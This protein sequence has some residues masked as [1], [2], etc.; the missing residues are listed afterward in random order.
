[1]QIVDPISFALRDEPPALPS[2]NLDAEPVP[3]AIKPQPISL[4]RILMPLIMEVVMLAMVAMMILTSNGAPNPMM[5]MFPMMMIA[6]MAMM[7]NPQSGQDPDESRRTYLRHLGSLRE[8]A[9]KNGQAQRKN[10]L[11]HHPAPRD[12]VQLAGTTRMWERQGSDDDAYEVRVG[13]GSATLSTPIN[14]S[15]SGATEDLDP[16]CAVSLRHTLAAVSTVTDMPI[17]LQLQAFRFLGITGANARELAR[18]M[19]LQL[20]TFHGPEAIGFRSIGQGWEWLKWLPHTRAPQQAHFVCLLVDDT[21]TTGLEPFM[22][23]PDVDCIIDI[24]SRRTTALGVRAEQEGL[25]LLADASLTVLTSD[26][27]EEL[28]RADGVSEAEAIVGARALARFS[29]PEVTSAHT[30]DDL[31]GLLGFGDVAEMTGP[32]L[33]PGRRGAARL[34]VPIGLSPSKLPVMLD[35]KESAQGGMGPHGL[36][37]GA[38]GSGKS[39]ALRTIVVSLAATH[40]PDELNFVLVDFKGGATFL[41]CD[42]LPHTAAVITNLEDESALVE[43]MYDAISGEMNRRQEI[44]RD[45]GNFAN[46][47]DYT[48]ARLSGRDDLPAL[49]ALVIVVDEFSELLMQHPDFA[50]LF[51]AVGRLGR[52][53]HVHLLLASQRLEE[54]R[55]RGL[56]SHLSYRIGLKTFSAAESRQ[57][58]GV[59]D[60]YHLPAEPGAGYLKTDADAL[61]RFQAFYVSGG[62]PREAAVHDAPGAERL[63]ISE[64]TGWDEETAEPIKVET[65]IDDSTTLL[66]EVVDATREEAAR[67]GLKAH[68]VWLAPLPPAIEL[69]AVAVDFSPPGDGQI[70]APVGIIDRPFY[71]RQDQLLVNL[72]SGHMAICGGPQSGKSMALLTIVASLAA[73]YSPDFLRFYVIDLGGGQ[74]S[75]LNRLPHVAAV[76]GRH[77][78]EKVRR[79]IDE[80]MGLVEHPESRHTYLV[81]DGWHHMGVAGADFEDLSEPI[82]RLAVDGPSARVHVIISTPRWTTMR[83]A[84]RD[85]ITERLE[86]K[87]G[88]PM[89]SLFDRKKQQKLPNLPGRGITPEGESMLMAATSRQDLAH[90]ESLWT[91]VAP[92]PELKM[93]P[94]TLSVADLVT[95]DASSELERNPDVDIR[96]PWARGGRDLETQTWDTR[97]NFFIVGTSGVGKS[98]VVATLLQGIGK[99]DRAD[100][101]IVLIDQRRAHLGTVDESMLAAYSA[102]SAATEKVLRDTATTLAARLPGPDIT[103]AQLTERSWWT[104]PDIYVVIDDL[105]LVSDMALAPIVELLPHARDIGLH[106]VA[107][108]KAGGIGRALFGQFLAQLRDTQ[109]AIFVMDTPRDEGA[110][111]GIKPAP[112]PIGRGQLAIGSDMVGL[113]QAALP[114]SEG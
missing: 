47:T 18:A 84:I 80:V 29:R 68:R 79:V 33:W 16:V 113:C 91:H 32:A 21:T 99:L 114:E 13:I 89:D 72:S 43:R 94:A 38:T 95:T 49:P 55:L 5:L 67:R 20:A 40:S 23:D 96:I 6:S 56:D 74:L 87:L 4:M 98:T 100:A 42:H 52:S 60:A 28:G 53:L 93:L 66:A 12:L 57:V 90:I 2:G 104:G 11:H 45:A 105:D 109:P 75:G 10:A 9:L 24:S 46:V 61:A 50:E 51:V 78:E 83:P 103:P 69:P 7:F 110:I 108:R 35:L 111:F 73:A 37:I 19:V 82:T 17:T 15:E 1:M 106:I 14:V 31:L 3:Q 25:V 59:S 107:A 58:L 81:I 77:E 36:C 54:G 30:R 48:T 26:G 101:R 71:Q 112:Q 64:F 39:E 22:D 102:T 44:L 92:V 70:H 76:A 88:E 65:Y 97:H 34:A 8:A 27:A 62:L 86:L 63:P 85:L 41:G